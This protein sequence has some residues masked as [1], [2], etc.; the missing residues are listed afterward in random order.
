MVLLKQI[1]KSKIHLANVPTFEH[2]ER[3]YKQNSLTSHA[4]KAN[5]PGELLG[6]TMKPKY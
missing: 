5:T 6:L 2:R 1:D 4:D 3:H